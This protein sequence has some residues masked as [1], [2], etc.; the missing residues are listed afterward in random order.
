LYIRN[1][2]AGIFAA[3]ATNG[4]KVRMIG[5]KRLEIT[6]MAPCFS[7]KSCA[8]SRCLRLSSRLCMPVPSPAAKTRG[9]SARPIA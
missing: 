8:R 3:P 1:F 7:K 6:A 9:P 4:T 5:A 2:G